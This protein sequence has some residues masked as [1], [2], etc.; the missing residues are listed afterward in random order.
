M[1]PSDFIQERVSEINQ[2]CV[3][4]GYPFDSGD[5]AYTFEPNPSFLFC[6]KNC[7]NLHCES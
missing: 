6:S 4:C 7:V 3:E 1:V 2:E 5:K